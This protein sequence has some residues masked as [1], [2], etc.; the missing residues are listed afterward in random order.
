[1]INNKDIKIIDAYLSGDLEEG[2]KAEFEKRLEEDNNFRSEFER[3]K[4]IISS[5]EDHALKQDFRRFHQ[6]FESENKSGAGN[7]KIYFAWGVAASVVILLSVAIFFISMENEKKYFYSY[8]EPYPNLI[9]TRSINENDDLRSALEYYNQKD[10][11]KAVAS[12]ESCELTNPNSMSADV[13]FYFAISYLGGEEPK[14][15]LKIFDDIYDSK[16]RSQINW[17]KSL[18]YLLL[19]EKTKG[20][21]LLTE[22]ERG[23][24]NYNS[25]QELLIYLNDQ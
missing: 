22:F 12:F 13:K 7:R 6:E 5:I 10:Y 20:R 11:K 2:E 17:Y 25:A 18:S 23:D 9:T 3:V 15:A 1:M 24:F 4:T 16:Y 14:K 21:S 19:E 8:F